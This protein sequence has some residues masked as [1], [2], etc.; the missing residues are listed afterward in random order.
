MNSPPRTPPRN[1]ATSQRTPPQLTRRQRTSR[2][3]NRQRTPIFYNGRPPLTQRSGI[4][5]V[6][7]HVLGEATEEN[8]GFYD[9]TPSQENHNYSYG[10]PPSSR[11]QIL[12]TPTQ[13]TPLFFNARPPRNFNA[14]Q[15]LTPPTAP[16]RSNE[17]HENNRNNRNNR[18]IFNE[19]GLNLD[20]N[21]NYENEIRTPPPLPPQL[22]RTRRTRRR[23]L[24]SP[25]PQFRTRGERLFNYNEG[26]NLKGAYRELAPNEIRRLIQNRPPHV[27]N[28][29]RLHSNT[30]RNYR[31][32]NQYKKKQRL[33][34]ATK[35]NNIQKARRT[36][37][38]NYYPNNQGYLPI[39]AEVQFA[40]EG[41][42][43]NQVLNNKA[44]KIQKSLRNY[45]NTKKNRN[46]LNKSK[47]SAKKIQKI[48]RKTKRNNR[49]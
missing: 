1:R 31:K 10:T 34:K 25:E 26:R 37:I 18:N 48:F 29:K 35:K 14:R 45:R 43:I 24:Q 22:R 36:T 32:S 23:S 30:A 11:E 8:H 12:T 40:N 44:R 20:G 9:D 28:G 47:R 42:Y 41:N 33:P 13:T 5:E 21:L 39:E 17:I 3:N 38:H 2:R 46:K 49:K 15:I 4:Q 19:L 6:S 7:N 16:R 27:I